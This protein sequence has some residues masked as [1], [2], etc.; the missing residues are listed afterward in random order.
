MAAFKAQWMLRGWGSIRGSGGPSGS[1][2]GALYK[3]SRIT[4]NLEL[5]SALR[6]RKTIPVS[7]LEFDGVQL[8][9]VRITSSFLSSSS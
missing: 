5:Q 1:L 8:Q 6:N 7:L 3:S 2:P 4:S 9:A